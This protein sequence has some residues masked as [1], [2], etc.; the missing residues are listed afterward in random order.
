MKVETG[1]FF[2]D[3]NLLGLQPSSAADADLVLSFLSI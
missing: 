1:N 2:S 3:L